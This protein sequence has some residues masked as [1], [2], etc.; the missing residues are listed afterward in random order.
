MPAGLN[1]LQK[2]QA[3]IESTRGTPIAATRIVY[4]DRGAWFEQEVG[5]E[6]PEEDRNSFI[7]NYRT[8]TVS[9]VAKMSAVARVTFDDLPWW[10]QFFWKGGVTGV[11]SAVTVYTYTFTPTVATDDLKTMTLEVG[12]DTQ[13]YRIP[14]GLAQKLEISWTRNQGV[15]MNVE[16]LGQQV[17]PNAFTGALSDRVLEDVVGTTAKVWI[18]NAG[19]TLGTTQALNVLSGKITWENNWTQITHLA[20]NLYPDDA[21]RAP[22]LA[23]LELD[24]HFNNTTEFAQL[25]TGGERLIR[26]QFTGTIIPGSTGN[27]LKSITMD[28]YGFYMTAPFSVDGPIRVVKVVADSVYDATATKDWQVAIANQLVTL[29]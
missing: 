12:N 29:P 5:R 8:L 26:V 3:G 18:D 21:Q 2:A 4:L 24:I 7:D 15:K 28:F 19:G 16:L 9:H 25:L 27:I 10:G 11:L 17:T 22:R 6:M 14:Y 23:H 20:G 13:A 1:A